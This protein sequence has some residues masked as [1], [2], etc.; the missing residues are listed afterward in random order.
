LNSVFCGG[1]LDEFS[2][3]SPIGSKDTATVGI[4]TAIA[5]VVLVGEVE[6]AFT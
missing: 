3:N 1:K 6:V 4:I 5:A 2:V